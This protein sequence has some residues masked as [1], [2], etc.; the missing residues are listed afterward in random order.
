MTSQIPANSIINFSVKNGLLIGLI[1]VVLNIVF[2]FIDPLFSFTNTW[3]GIFSFVLLITLLVVLGLD[4]RKK[5][6]GFWS[7]GQALTSLI[8][9]SVIVVLLSTI[10]SFILFKFIDPQLPAKATAALLE[11]TTAMLE[12]LG[13]DQSKIDESTQSFRNGEMEAKLQPTL[14][15]EFITFI[16]GVAVYGVI[17]LIIAAIIKKKAPLVP[18]ASDDTGAEV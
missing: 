16:T 4:V 17:S 11:K 1:V 3:V 2:Y 12:K 13:L 6:G 9:M 7:Y 18:V 10:Y 15:N 8:I 5:N 14:K